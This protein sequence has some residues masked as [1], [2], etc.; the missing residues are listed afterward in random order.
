MT[1]TPK[2]KQVVIYRE[3][4]KERNYLLFLLGIFFIYIPNFIPFPHFPFENPP[5]PYPLHVLINT[6]TPTSLSSD[7]TTLGHRALTR[8][9]A[10]AFI[11]VPQ[12]H[13]LLQMVLEP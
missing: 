1:E 12:Y 8:P 6:P 13:P 4:Y 9:R 7:S 11:D 2:A 3:I 10:S 5:T